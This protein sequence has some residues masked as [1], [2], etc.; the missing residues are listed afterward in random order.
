MSSRKLNRRQAF[1]TAAAAGLFARGASAAAARTDNVYTRIGG[2][3]FINLT[4]TYTIN[5]GALARPEVIRAMEEASHH[6]VNLDELM[7]AVGRRL[8]ELLGSESAMVTSGCA[9]ALAHATAACVAGGD[10]EKMQQIPRLDG[11]KD[12]VIMPRQSRNVYDHAIRMVGIRMVTVDSSEEFYRA[13]GPKTAMVAVLGTG[14]AKGKI[15]LEEIAAAARKANVPVLVDAAAELPG[16]PNTYLARGADLVAYSG[17]KFLR[18]PQCAGLLL[19]RRDLVQAAW[20]NSSPHHAFG[21]AMK[22]GKEEI[23][24]MLAAIEIWRGGYDLQGE[25]RKWEGWFEHIREKITAVSGVQAEVKPA[26]GASP[27]PVLDVAWDPQ[28]IGMTA[29]EIGRKLLDGEPRIMS[30]AE[31]DGHGFVIR[32][33]AMQEGEYKIVADRLAA[34]LREAPSGA[35]PRSLNPP[36]LDLTGRW[37]VELEF[38][39][40]STEHQ[41]TLEAAGNR[42]TGSHAGR[43]AKGELTGEIDG[44]RVRLRGSLPYEGT[45]LGYDFTGTVAAGRMSGEV[46]L[47]EYGKARWQARRA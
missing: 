32:P 19:G 21:R 1:Q 30:H 7:A 29:G 35:A 8:A 44:D 20:L 23:M 39:S 33:V 6:P 37:L 42:L 4:A 47:G 18:G 16:V 5:G 26:S 46:G 41:I 31:G 22:V 27:F 3:P 11:L 28:R 12:Q 34:I 15:R 24:G 13:L 9:A 36:A 38:V 25:Y 40:G 45:R 2:R 17:G 43:I 14:E 10:P